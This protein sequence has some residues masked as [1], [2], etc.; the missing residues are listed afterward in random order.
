VFDRSLLLARFQVHQAGKVGCVQAS[1]V[2]TV[3][4]LPVIKSLD[5][6]LNG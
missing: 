4:Q 6:E 2:E 5:K 1:L 3:K